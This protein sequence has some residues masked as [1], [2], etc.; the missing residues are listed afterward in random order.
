MCA[1]D[2]VARDCRPYDPEES[3]GRRVLLEKNNATS[4]LQALNNFMNKGSSCEMPRLL[5]ARLGAPF[6]IKGHQ[7]AVVQAA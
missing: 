2:E 5:T 1:A 7:S 3:M 4:I 6:K